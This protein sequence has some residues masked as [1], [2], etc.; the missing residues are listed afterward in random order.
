MAELLAAEGAGVHVLPAT[1]LRHVPLQ[2]GQMTEAASTVRA[3]E[4]AVR[5][6]HATVRLEVSHQAE[7]FSAHG[8]TERFLSRVQAYVQLLS[9][10]GLKGFT[11]EGARLT[12]LLVRLQVRCQ[13]VCRVQTLTTEATECV[14]VG[15]TNLQ[16]MLEQE[17]F[18]VQRATTYTTQEALR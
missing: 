11:T 12:A 7:L 8:A 15:G 13:L 3:L 1:M 10:D 14:W 18:A 4:D 9:Q 6:V 2:R 17:S 5:H 16:H